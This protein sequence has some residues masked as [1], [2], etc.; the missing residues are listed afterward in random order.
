MDSKLLSLTPALWVIVI[1]LLRC[2]RSN[3]C[4]SGYDPELHSASI[5]VDHSRNALWFLKDYKVGSKSTRVPKNVTALV[6]IP[7]NTEIRHVQ[8]TVKIFFFKL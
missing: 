1:S 6:V 4:L 2:R 5:A 3:N 8:D 7:L